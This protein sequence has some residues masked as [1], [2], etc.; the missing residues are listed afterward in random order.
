MNRRNVRSTAVSAVA[1]LTMLLGAAATAV[2]QSG[3][4]YSF[5]KIEYP[6]AALTE[7][8]GINN[9]GRVVGTYYGVDGV[10]H[11]FVYNGASYV[12]VDFPGA[13]F[14][15]L[16]G[17]NAAGHIVGSYSLAAAIGPYHGLSV[18]SGVFTTF[19]FPNQETDGRAIN[20]SGHIVGIYD[21]AFG[22]PDHGFFKTGELFTSIDVLGATH[23][24]AFGLNDSGKIT[25]TY[26]DGIGLHGWM[27]VGGTVATINVPGATH[28]FVGGINNSDMIVGWSGQP[29]KPS[30]FILSGSRF[31]SFDA[32]FPNVTATRPWAINDL[33]QV[34]GQ[35]TSSDCP[36]GCSFLATPT[37]GVPPLCAQST[38]LSY[39]GNTFTQSFTL[40]S[41]VPL[42]WNQW[43]VIA[44]TPLRLWSLSLP[45]IS[46]PVSFDV[47]I[48]GFPPLGT[49]LGATFLSTA[50]GDTV[51]F[52]IASVNTSAAATTTP[53]GR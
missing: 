44:N 39:A 2:G 17:I 13:P 37:T 9:A 35:Y 28:T 25:G 20:A 30:G 27:L 16:F 42:V 26:V 46:A 52:D 23:T 8:T 45:A 48:P 38:S 22:M 19:D 11:G 53:S 24:Y 6:G 31:R 18:V 21:A 10:S 51:C 43:L 4:P 29:T 1:I 40:Q 7:A 41:S 33:G 36:G 47:P 32:N 12:T 49:V 14:T 50:A 34:V 5:M 3:P 15:Y